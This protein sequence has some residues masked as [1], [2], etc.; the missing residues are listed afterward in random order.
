MELVV[1]MCTDT[2]GGRG[3]SALAGRRKGEPFA[4]FTSYYHNSLAGTT[5]QTVYYALLSL[6]TYDVS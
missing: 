3:Y 6:A 2:L 1:I 4:E 5:V